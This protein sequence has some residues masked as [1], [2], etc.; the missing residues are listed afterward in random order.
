MLCLVMGE[1]RLNTH[2]EFFIVKTT[3][4]PIPNNKS[5]PMI[6]IPNLEQNGLDHLN[7]E[8]KNHLG[9]KDLGFEVKDVTYWKNAYCFAKRG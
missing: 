3:K 8:L 4:S 7:L 9:F 6:R 5:F 1:Y 2:S